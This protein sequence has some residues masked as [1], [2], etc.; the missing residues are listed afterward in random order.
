MNT[1]R[2]NKVGRLIQKDLS[3]VFI[4]LTR[5]HFHGKMISVSGVLVTAD[6]SFANVYISIFPSKYK[7]EILEQITSMQKYIKNEVAKK[8]RNQLRKMQE[9]RFFIDDSLDQA[10]KIKKLLK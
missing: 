8:V 4:E 7:D 2:Q 6:F 9:L 5:T 10:E 1:T 3:T